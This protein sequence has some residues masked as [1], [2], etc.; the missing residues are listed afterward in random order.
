MQ[1]NWPTP[2]AFFHMLCLD[3]YPILD[4]TPVLDI[5]DLQAGGFCRSVAGALK[6]AEDGSIPRAWAT[7]FHG[8]DFI[9]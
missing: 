5:P 7:G 4:L 2:N 9:G 6:K 3:L 8:L 1:R